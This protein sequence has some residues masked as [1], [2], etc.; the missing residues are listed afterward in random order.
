VIRHV[1]TRSATYDFDGIAATG[2]AATAPSAGTVFTVNKEL[3]AGGTTQ[4]GTMTFAMSANDGVWADTALGD[5]TFAAGDRI[6]IVA[7]GAVNG[8]AQLAI[9]VP[10]VLP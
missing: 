9:T 10:L 4:L 1:M 7:P 5:V 2:Y 6:E 3:L 8:I